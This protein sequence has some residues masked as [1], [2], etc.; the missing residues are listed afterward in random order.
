[1]K[2]KLNL[3]FIAVMATA[4]AV[5]MIT[6]GV[7]YV[8]I[9]SPHPDIND[10]LKVQ[11]AALAYRDRLTAQGAPIP[12]AVTLEDLT[13]AGMLQPDEVKGFAGMQVTVALNVDV[14][15]P[16]AIIMRVRMPDGKEMAAL[17][18]GSV[19]ELTPERLR[20]LLQK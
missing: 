4:T 12:E 8:G 19:Q 10:Y 6:A 13:A 9:R 3:K 18:D 7:F 17:G 20:E 1:M 5:L 11:T 15:M 16:R 14:K 2:R